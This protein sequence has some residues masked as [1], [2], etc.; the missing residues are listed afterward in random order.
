MSSQFLICILPSERPFDA[1]L[2][3]I[4]ALLP[5]VDL[6]IERGTIRQAPVKALTIKDADFDF[7]HVE[8][9]GMLRGVVEYDAAQQC[10]RFLNAEHF[11]ET[12]A[13]M[14]VEVIHDQMDAVCRDIN[15]SEQMPDEGHEVG[16]GPVIH[17]LA[18]PP[19]ALIQP[20][21][22]YIPGLSANVLVIHPH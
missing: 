20:P 5:G 6:G 13:E 3:R 17:V 9:T 2:L 14:G 1:S 7:G 4:A 22:D 8:P 11:L 19:L 15:L 16:L 12:L 10:L 21:H 18:G